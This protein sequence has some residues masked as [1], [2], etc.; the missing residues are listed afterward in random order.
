[1]E[2]SARKICPRIAAAEVAVPRYRG[3]KKRGG[4][5]VATDLQLEEAISVDTGCQVQNC[6]VSVI[7]AF[8]VKRVFYDS[9]LGGTISV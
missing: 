8:G 5:P 4:L 9:E 2:F 6:K 7:S 3:C 1:M